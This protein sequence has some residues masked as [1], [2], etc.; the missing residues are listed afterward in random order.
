MKKA[1]LSERIFVM[2]IIGLLSFST[3]YLG[4]LGTVAAV[5]NGLGWGL[6]GAAILYLRK[7]SLN[8]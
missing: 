2:V 4:D 6:L 5:I 1:S 7:V 8:G 3:T